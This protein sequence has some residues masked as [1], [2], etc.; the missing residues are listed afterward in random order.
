MTKYLVE[1]LHNTAAFWYGMPVFQKSIF[2]LKS[3]YAVSKDNT[4]TPTIPQTGNF[5]SA[6][7]LGLLASLTPGSPVFS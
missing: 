1:K 7:L 4:F 5:S 3:Y 2:V 6:G